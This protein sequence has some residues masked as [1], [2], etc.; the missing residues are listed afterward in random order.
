MR[1]VVGAVYR[2]GTGQTGAD[3]IRE[4]IAVMEQHGL[5]KRP[6]QLWRLKLLAE[7]LDNPI[8]NSAP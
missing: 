5:T 6:D 8:P 3:L 7:Y 4:I 1:G 2:T